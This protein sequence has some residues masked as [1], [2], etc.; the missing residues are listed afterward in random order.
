ML[1]AVGSLVSSVSPQQRTA[2]TPLPP[3]AVRPEPPEPPRRAPEPRGDRDA[4]LPATA[5]PPVRAAAPA[6]PPVTRP[7]EPTTEGAREPWLNGTSGHRRQ[8]AEHDR[9]PVAGEA[10]DRSREDDT[11]TAPT[12]FGPAH[13]LR[14]DSEDDD[15]Q[16]IELL[17]E[18]A[19]R[20]AHSAIDDSVRQAQTL[21]RARAPRERSLGQHLDQRLERLDL[22][23]NNLSTDVR[24][25]QQRLDRIEALL[26][27]SLEGR[28]PSVSV[29]E[30]RTAEPAE[31][32]YPS[33]ASVLP[34]RGARHRVAPPMPRTALPPLRRPLDEPEAT[35]EVLDDTAAVVVA[36]VTP[37]IGA[38]VEDFTP[39]DLAPPAPEVRDLVSTAHEPVAE[40]LAELAEAHAQTAATFA[41]T[42]EDH[43]PEPV[44]E[45]APAEVLDDAES[46]RVEAATEVAEPEAAA[47][48][49]HRTGALADWGRAPSTP[50][51]V[52]LPDEPAPIE[53]TEPRSALAAWPGVAAP[54]DEVAAEGEPDVEV[55]SAEALLEVHEAV[56]ALKAVEVAEVPDLVAE[57]PDLVVEVAPPV[58]P[59][60]EVTEPAADAPAVEVAPEVR[61]EEPAALAPVPASALPPSMLAPERVRFAAEAGSVVLRISPISGFQG[62]MR[63]QD[64]LARVSS[65][66]EASVEAY[67][68]GE[69]RLRIRLG[70]ET[71]AGP[72]ATA[73]SERLNQPVRLRE[74]SSAERT[75]SVALG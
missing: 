17:L 6:A 30:Q 40:A 53:V 71:G 1:R 28:V 58:A 34:A 13:D 72:L 67:S 24:A 38:P 74:V 15:M 20:R 32:G 68:Q 35:V 41:E 59:P 65:V 75:M 56:E 62:L 36:P 2:R 43:L 70:Q 18:D 31:L 9:E 61:L 22:S 49:P 7:T 64:A 10:P 47:E 54:A 51:P 45:W 52:E 55:E 60:S 57:T 4:T 12:A 69:A 5:V 46:P 23:V 21:L 50:A 39:V 66:R 19:R 29:S 33:I 8:P 42:A 73:L 26:R 14:P 48:P 27:E 11:A 16:E 37:V 25:V 63:V 3:P 44:A